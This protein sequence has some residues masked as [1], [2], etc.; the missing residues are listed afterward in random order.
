[1]RSGQ[2]SRVL[3]AVVGMVAAALIVVMGIAMTRE[4]GNDDLGR[5]STELIFGPDFD[6][7]GFNGER[8]VL[9]EHAGE[10]VFV[11]FWA[12][13]CPPCEREAPLIQE[14]W[15]EYERQGYTFVGVNMWDGRDDALAFVDR[16]GITFPIV[17]DDG[18]T[19][20][21]YGVYLLPEAFFLRPGLTLEQKYNGELTEDAFRERLAAIGES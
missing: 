15:P 4:V 21:D 3:V 19:Y 17:I 13:W 10:P 20:L 7:P 1:M 11:Y 14:L 6:L 9:A 18:T 16:H 5:A 8:F 2:L 12:S